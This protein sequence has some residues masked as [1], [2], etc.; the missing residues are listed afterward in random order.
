[1]FSSNHVPLRF[2]PFSG[3]NN[4]ETICRRPAQ[5]EPRSLVRSFPLFALPLPPPPPSR[6]GPRS[7]RTGWSGTP[8]CRACE[9]GRDVSW[10]GAIYRLSTYTLGD[11]GVMR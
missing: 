4:I 6:H 9:P 8:V 11:L 10:N 1:M 7:L 2:F 5:T 3:R